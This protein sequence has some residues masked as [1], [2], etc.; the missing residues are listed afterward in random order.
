[1]RSI[2][3]T[4]VCLAASLL[5]LSSCVREQETAGRA[6]QDV[7]ISLLTTTRSGGSE[8]FH[9]DDWKIS[10]LR[11]MGFGST[12]A[13]AFNRT[14]T[15]SDWTTSG[16]DELIKREAQVT[17]KTGRY[18]VVFVA[19]EG[20]Q[21]GLGTTLDAIGSLSALRGIAFGNGAFDS[22]KDIPM[23]AF[24]ENV[25]ILGDND[26]KVG[27]S[28]VAGGVWQIQM[29]RL[30]VRADI[31]LTLTEEQYTKWGN[32]VSTGAMTN[33]PITIA[34]VPQQVFLFPGTDNSATGTVDKSYYAYT[35]NHVNYSK[36]PG[37][38]VANGNTV[39]VT[40][41]RIIL[42][43]SWFADKT[44]SAKAM[45]LQIRLKEVT[46]AAV[47]LSGR[48]GNEITTP[49]L[50][51]TLPR[52]TYLGITAT[53]DEGEELLPTNVYHRMTA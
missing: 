51:Y 49:P 11:I 28:A 27:G 35:G 30:G 36:G 29:E 19:N 23:A 53:V 7:R 13:L 31:T 26:L 5:A 33:L 14:L 32:S 52:N 43:E 47:T 2:L 34:G 18:L 8:Q 45:Q 9:A 10:T 48:I 41:P 17:V 39:T 25:E 1:M 21:S 22:A 3:I 16:T 15:T 40:F 6:G 42:P 24:Y 50:D 4:V 38:I 46:Q 12:G 20:S 44:N 37:A